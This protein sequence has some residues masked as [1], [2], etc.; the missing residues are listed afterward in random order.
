MYLLQLTAAWSMPTLEIRS[1]KTSRSL[2]RD[3]TM[4]AVSPIWT[5]RS[6]ASTMRR[7]SSLKRLHPSRRL[8]RMTP[9]SL[10]RISGSSL[11]RPPHPLARITHRIYSRTI[12]MLKSFQTFSAI[13][14][15]RPSPH[16]QAVLIGVGFNGLALFPRPLWPR[17]NRSAYRVPSTL[18]PARKSKWR[19]S[20]SSS[21]SGL[22]SIERR[23]AHPPSLSKTF[24]SEI[25][26]SILKAPRSGTPKQNLSRPL[27]CPRALKEVKLPRRARRLPPSL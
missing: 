14:R 23:M 9:R 15:K 3:P 7:R 21:R 4:H 18:A 6:K 17:R 16:K 5:S 26:S 1:V 27:P 13:E 19:T 10:S 22:D 12:R 11:L 8:T 24:F 2:S 25:R 20:S